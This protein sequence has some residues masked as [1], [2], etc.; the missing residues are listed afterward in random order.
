MTD[1]TDQ[2]PLETQC[3]QFPLTPDQA[4]ALKP[5]LGSSDEIAIQDRPTQSGDACAL[6]TQESRTRMRRQQFRK[7]RRQRA[8]AQ[9]RAERRQ[10][11]LTYAIENHLSEQ[12]R[13]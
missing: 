11:I 3:V 10:T 4:E 2:L 1:S 5:A 8:K 6:D 12:N 7:R 9:R 13:N